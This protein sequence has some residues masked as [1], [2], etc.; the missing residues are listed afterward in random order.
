MDDGLETVTG[1]ELVKFDK[2]GTVIY[3]QLINYK[4]QKTNKGDGHVYEVKTKNGLSPFF[5]PTLLHD[6]L[7]NIP[8]GSI[9]KITFVEIKR[10]NSGND[11]KVF[12]VKHGPAN[13]KTL[14]AAGITVD[15]GLASTDL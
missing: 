15:D 1:G 13:E 9:V 5:A 7:K 10:G 11:Y 4:T 12:D 6:K 2:P 8:V 14:A 3:G